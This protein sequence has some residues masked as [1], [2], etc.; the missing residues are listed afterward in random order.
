MTLEEYK[1]KRMEDK[2]FKTI[3]DETKE[4]LKRE[5]EETEKFEKISKK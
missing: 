2:D 3:Y 1:N 4:E 5:M